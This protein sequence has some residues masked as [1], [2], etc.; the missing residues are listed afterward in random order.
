MI[1]QKRPLGIVSYE[2]PYRSGNIF[3]AKICDDHRIYDQR[4]DE[5]FENSIYWIIYLESIFNTNV[6]KRK[7][8]SVDVD[9]FM[10]AFDVGDDSARPSRSDSASPVITESDSDEEEDIYDDVD[11]DSDVYSTPVTMTCHEASMATRHTRI[12]RE[13]S[14]QDVANMSSSPP[15]EIPNRFIVRDIPPTTEPNWLNEDVDEPSGSER[16]LCQSSGTPADSTASH[17]HRAGRR[18]W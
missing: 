16:V 14:Y 6:Q 13:S 3:R 17:I 7:R 1:S 18:D 8:K 12:G 2:C 11:M 4:F 15:V 9:E 5:Y 10:F